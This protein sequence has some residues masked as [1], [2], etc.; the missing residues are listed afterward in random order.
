[1]W[2]DDLIAELTSFPAGAHDDWCNALAMALNY[3]RDAGT[4]SIIVFQKMGCAA[5]W[6]REGRLSLEEAAHRAEVTT[7]ELERWLEPK[8]PAKQENSFPSPVNDAAELLLWNPARLVEAACAG[9]FVEID[10]DTYRLARRNALK[11]YAASCA[12]PENARSSPKIDR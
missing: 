8:R 11:A 4:P 5:S 10:P 1:M 12:D 7:A 6:V 9:Y 3:L 2:R